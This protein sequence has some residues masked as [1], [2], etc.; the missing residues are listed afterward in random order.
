MSEDSPLGN[1][2]E[3]LDESQKQEEKE[4]KDTEG[5]EEAKVEKDTEV[6]EEDERG[7]SFPF[8]EA[9]Q[10]PLYPHRDRWEELEDA[11]FEMEGFLRKQGVR[12]VQ[13]RE[14]DDA[15]LQYAISNP[16]E[17]AEL[18]LESRGIETEE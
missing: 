17:V 13:G 12:D 9:K 11:K 10:S 3:Q 2:R 6:E 18:V 5:T 15:I 4:T 1:I 7:P 8:S 14:L 16:E